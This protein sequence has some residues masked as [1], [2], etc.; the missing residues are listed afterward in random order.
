MI[1]FEKSKAVTQSQY[2]TKTV[3]DNMMRPVSRHFDE[4]EG[5]IPWDYIEFMHAA[6]KGDG[7]CQSG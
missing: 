7:V 6:L 5:E 3:A 4:N 2:L 1:S